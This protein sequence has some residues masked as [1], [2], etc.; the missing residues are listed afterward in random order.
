MKVNT[1]VTL[2]QNLLETVDVLA[3]GSNRRSEFIEEA[4]RTYVVSMTDNGQRA[5]DIEIIN[6]HAEEL[7]EEAIDVLD[8]QVVCETRRPLPSFQA[9]VQRAKEVPCLRRC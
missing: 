9:F 4:L 7:N 8:Y 6:A 3:G 2:D 1:T 5:R